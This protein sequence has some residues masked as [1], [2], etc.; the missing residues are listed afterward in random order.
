MDTTIANILSLLYEYVQQESNNSLNSP[1]LLGLSGNTVWNT[2]S[3]SITSYPGHEILS[4]NEKRLCTNLRL[5]PSQYITYKTCILQ[6]HLQKKIGQAP[7]P[8]NPCGLDKNDRK[9]IFNF[10][11]RAGWIT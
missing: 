9:V 10:L 1:Q 4:T 6:D 11:M 3:F 5:T 8:L 7:K 2:K